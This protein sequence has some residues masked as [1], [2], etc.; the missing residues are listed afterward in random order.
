MRWDNLF[1]ISKQYAL[2][3]GDKNANVVMGEKK[4]NNRTSSK[5]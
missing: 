2:Q 1:D 3:P 4:F 5:K